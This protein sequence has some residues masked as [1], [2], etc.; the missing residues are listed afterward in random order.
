MEYLTEM[1]KEL[2]SVI[3]PCYNVEKYIDRCMES[4]LNQTYRNLEIILVD[5]GSTDGTGKLLRNMPSMIIESKY[6][7]R[8]IKAPAQPEMREWK[9]QVGLISDLWTA[10]TGSR[11]ICMSIL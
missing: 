6:C 2:I 11:K 4:V 1:E 3:I 8:K 9:S 7:I 5:D 10:M